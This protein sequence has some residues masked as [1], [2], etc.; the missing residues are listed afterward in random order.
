MSLGLE[1]V[2]L[3]LLTTGS[4]KLELELPDQR[5]GACWL[6]PL[7]DHTTRLFVIDRGQ[8]YQ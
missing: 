8:P 3:G 1:V 2:V 4:A 5:I 7:V 6:E